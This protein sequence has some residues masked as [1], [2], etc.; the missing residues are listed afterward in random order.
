VLGDDRLR[1]VSLRPQPR[2]TPSR[3]WSRV[4]GGRRA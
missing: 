2:G 4:R 1:G 3:G